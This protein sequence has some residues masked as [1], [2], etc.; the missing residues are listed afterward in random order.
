MALYLKKRLNERCM[1]LAITEEALYEPRVSPLEMIGLS[2]ILD[3]HKKYVGLHLDFKYPID[4][5]DLAQAMANTLD[6]SEID[7]EAIVNF[8][9]SQDGCFYTQSTS[10]H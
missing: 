9:V 7:I 5:E 6:C 2:V 10:L 3:D 8:L 4:I 1:R